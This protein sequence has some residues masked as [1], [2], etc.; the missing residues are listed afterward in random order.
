MTTK[1][2]TYCRLAWF[3]RHDI[4]DLVTLTIAISSVVSRI[5]VVAV[6][7]GSQ[8]GADVCCDP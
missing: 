3:G 2:A 7:L 8:I 4:I 1:N 6:V 5:T